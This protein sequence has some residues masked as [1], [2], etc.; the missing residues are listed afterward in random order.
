MKIKPK[1][2]YTYQ[3]QIN[4]AQVYD[5]DTLKKVLIDLGF[6]MF[7]KTDLRLARIN[8]PEIRTRNKEEKAAGYISRD[9]LAGLLVDSDDI[10]VHV[11]K[12]G[13]FGRWI[14]EIYKDGKNIND[15]MVKTGHA[16]EYGKHW[17]DK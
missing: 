12:K 5:G 17:G 4:K 15:L 14:A 3:V 6:N 11:L 10:T 2:L 8:T 9:Y 1:Q 13:K 7:I 16:M